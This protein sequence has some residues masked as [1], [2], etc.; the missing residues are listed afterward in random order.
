MLWKWSEQWPAL[1]RFSTDDRA[2]KERHY[3]QS[4]IFN[5]QDCL[6]NLFLPDPNQD[7]VEDADGK[8]RNYG[9][10]WP[11]TKRA[12]VRLNCW[13]HYEE[14]EKH[15]GPLRFGNRRTKARGSLLPFKGR[16]KEEDDEF[17][18]FLIHASQGNSA[19]MEKDI[20]LEWRE[21]L[22]AVVL[23]APEVQQQLKTQLREMNGGLSKDLSIHFLELQE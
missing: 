18:P 8:R 15:A 2:A 9:W 14:I 7:I 12:V 1:S 10:N 19:Q 11:Y 5:D 13:Y 20:E 17:S 16:I 21:G 4:A 6:W 22:E 3:W 23:C